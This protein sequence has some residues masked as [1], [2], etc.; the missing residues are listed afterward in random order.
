[1][2][3][4]EPADLLRDPVASPFVQNRAREGRDHRES[5]STSPGAA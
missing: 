3:N 4:A 1:M 5:L 2:P